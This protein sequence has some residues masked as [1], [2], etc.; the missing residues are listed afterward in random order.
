MKPVAIGGFH[1]D[2]IRLVCILRVTDQG[3]I[4]VADITGENELPLHF[5]FCQPYLNTGRTKQ[6]T[7]IQ[8]AHGDSLGDRI[9]LIIGMGDKAADRPQCLLHGIQRNVSILAAALCLAVAPFRFKFL[10]VRTVTEHNL[11]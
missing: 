11:T 1:D 2:I 3:L 8:K 10:N 7:R 6:M 5:A 4:E 9:L